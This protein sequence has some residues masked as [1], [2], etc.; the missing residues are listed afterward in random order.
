[1]QC[2]RLSTFWCTAR[3][4][5]VGVSEGVTAAGVHVWTRPGAMFWGTGTAT[6]TRGVGM[7]PRHLSTSTMHRDQQ[8]RSLD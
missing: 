6:G 3:N 4:V 2:P 5:G 8:V 1:M 7:A